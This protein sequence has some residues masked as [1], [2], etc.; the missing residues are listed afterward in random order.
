MALFTVKKKRKEEEVV[1]FWGEGR[2]KKAA[3]LRRVK[4]EREF[5][6]VLKGERKELVAI[7]VGATR[8]LLC[9]F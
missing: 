2:D 1:Y 3:N 7:L 9:L 4:G 6:F 5:C 8:G